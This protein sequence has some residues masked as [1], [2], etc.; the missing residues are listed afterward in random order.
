MSAPNVLKETWLRLTTH[1]PVSNRMC[2]D[3]VVFGS[4]RMFP[5]YGEHQRRQFVQSNTKKSGNIFC[6][7]CRGSG[8]IPA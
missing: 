6:T 7:V 1:L 5:M 2:D 8:H 3:G 4:L